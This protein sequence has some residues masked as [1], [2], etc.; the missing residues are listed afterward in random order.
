MTLTGQNIW[1]AVLL[2]ME[3]Q[4]RAYTTRLIMVRKSRRDDHTSTVLL[5]SY[6]FPGDIGSANK[7]G[8]RHQFVPVEHIKDTVQ[9]FPPRGMNAHKS[10]EARLKHDISEKRR[11]V[12]DLQSRIVRAGRADIDRWFLLPI[13][14]WTIPS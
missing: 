12:I 2:G 6:S 1:L 11:G 14:L 8:R 4:N 5:Q 9:Q 10:H 7:S 13:Y 3:R